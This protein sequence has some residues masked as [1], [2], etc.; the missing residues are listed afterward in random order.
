MLTILLD[1]HKSCFECRQNFEKRFDEASRLVHANPGTYSYLI[2]RNLGKFRN[3]C[4]CNMEMPRQ[5]DTGKFCTNMHT[6]KHRGFHN[7]RNLLWR[8]NFRY[9][10]ADKLSFQRPVINGNESHQGSLRNTRV[11]GHQKLLV[12]IS[13]YKIH[14]RNDKNCIIN[15]LK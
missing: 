11:D 1:C 2:N 12:W 13:F 15:L 8:K 14:L 6:M 3:C 10:I 5:P 9:T 7:A 4:G